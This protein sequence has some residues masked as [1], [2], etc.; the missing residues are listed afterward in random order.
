MFTCE[1]KNTINYDAMLGK[2]NFTQ[3]FESLSKTKFTKLLRFYPFS[4]T[5][6]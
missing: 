5:I 2:I 3:H 4:D 6:K 1:D